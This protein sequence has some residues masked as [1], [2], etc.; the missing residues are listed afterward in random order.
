MR[1]ARLTLAILAGLAFADA[2]GR[3][4]D[5]LTAEAGRGSLEAQRELGQAYLAGH[6]A[7]RDVERGIAL[8]SQAAEQRDPHAHQALADYYESLP[9]SFDARQRRLT[10]LRRAS[11]LGHTG[12]AEELALLLIDQ[13]KNTGLTPDD[14]QRTRDLALKLLEFASNAGNPS[15]A[16]TL[17]TLKLG[18]DLGA[19][20][21]VGGKGLLRRAADMGHAPSAFSLAREHL[22]HPKGDRALGIRYLELSAEHGSA[23]ASLDLARRHLDG[24]A[25]RRD[26]DAASRYLEQ[27]RA[28]GADVSL[29]AQRLAEIERRNM[30]AAIQLGATGAVERPPASTTPAARPAVAATQAQTAAAITPD[31]AR[32][33]SIPVRPMAPRAAPQARELAFEA[34]TATEPTLSSPRPAADLAARDGALLEFTDIGSFESRIAKLERDLANSRSLN[35]KLR[36][37]VRHNEALI[38]DLRAQRDRAVASA[39]R[40][41]ASVA[42]LEQAVDA[43]QRARNELAKNEKEAPKPP[44]RKPY[45]PGPPILPNRPEPVDEDTVADV[46]PDPDPDPAA[47]RAAEAEKAN[48]LALAAMR[49]GRA[50]DAVAHLKKAASAGRADAMNN[51]GMMYMK[52]VGVAP[53]TAMALVYL[54]R[55]AQGGNATAASNLG[56]IFQHGF[57]VPLN[58]ARAVE[59]YERASALGHQASAQQLRVLQARAATDSIV[60]KG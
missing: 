51:L 27:A 47:A 41:E 7:P 4:L 8:L 45:E 24:D 12:A 54:K 17:G 40:A 35:Q 18:R 9:P 6:G 13:A 10:H 1:I 46:D 56:Y 5:E 2:S 31:A 42:A 53:D 34:P 58:H 15:A 25:V 44:K 50:A 11:E 60:Q 39:A 22:D 3:G 55:A 29:L 48:A 28:R 52:G 21:P 32:D 14:Q 33:I 57:G 49:E 30:P 59:W 37:Q 19:P 23:A 38:A 16:A 20:D 26:T 36:D 43:F